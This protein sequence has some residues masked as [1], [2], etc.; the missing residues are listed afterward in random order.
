MGFRA[1]YQSALRQSRCSILVQ[2]RKWRGAGIFIC[3]ALALLSVVVFHG[4]RAKS[5]VPLLFIA[6]IAIVAR[7]FGTWSG[8]AGTVAATLIFAELLFEPL[9]S[10]RVADLNQRQNLVWMVIIGISLSELL[11]GRPPSKSVG[12]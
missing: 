12:K 7:R 3:I 6:V 1:A 2:F 4:S 9:F 8:V 5:V 11:G 10:I